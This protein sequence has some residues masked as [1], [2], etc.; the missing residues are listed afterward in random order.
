MKEVE[1][2][3]DEHKLHAGQAC[4][5]ESNITMIMIYWLLLL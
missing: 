2:N 3:A 1:L 5:S 4:D